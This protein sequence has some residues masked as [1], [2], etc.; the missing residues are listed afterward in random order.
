MRQF[1]E[2]PPPQWHLD[3]W[4]KVL[5]IHVGTAYV[6]RQCQNLVMVTKGGVGILDLDCCGKPMEKVEAKSSGRPGG[7]Q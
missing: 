7:E 1:P 6:C 5:T 4:E 3:E 2:S